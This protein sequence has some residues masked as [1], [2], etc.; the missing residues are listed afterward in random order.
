[1]HLSGSGEWI[2]RPQTVLAFGFVYFAVQA[3]VK[4][5]LS[6]A[7]ARPGEAPIRQSGPEKP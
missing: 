7:D 6:D 5:G 2:Q 1:M 3:W 4:Y